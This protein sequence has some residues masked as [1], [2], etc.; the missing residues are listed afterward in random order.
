MS[1]VPAGSISSKPTPMYFPPR[2]M[3]HAAVL[4]CMCRSGSGSNQPEALSIQHPACDTSTRPLATSN[5]THKRKASAAKANARKN[6]V[7]AKSK[8][9]DLVLPHS[10]AMC[11]RSKT[12]DSP[13]KSTRS[14]RKLLE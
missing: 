3:L 9:Q 8:K 12:G 11:T 14:K 4:K 13:A 7:T 6:K 5:P 2:Y 10:P 1:I